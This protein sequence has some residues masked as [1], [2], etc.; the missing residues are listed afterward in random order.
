MLK[1]FQTAKRVTTSNSLVLQMPVRY[2]STVA[3]EDRCIQQ[4]LDELDTKGYTVVKDIFT[5]EEVEAL[6]ADYAT[7]KEKAFG[8]IANTP[9][10]PRVWEES[11]EVTR[12]QYWR[13]PSELILQAGAGRYD[14]Y[15]G[16]DQG[17]FGSDSVVHNPVVAKL[18][19]AILVSEYTHYQGVIHSS[20][21]SGS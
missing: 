12:S 19:R 20:A 18:M 5:A 9:P 3:M 16:F 8:I 4:N 17:I 6:R 7:I 15:K 1:V 21:G 10:L 11:G 14:L 2:S 13:T